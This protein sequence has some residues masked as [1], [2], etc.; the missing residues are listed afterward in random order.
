MAEGSKS[1]SRDSLDYHLKVQTL[2]D[3]LDKCRT[4]VNS[5]KGIDVT[6]EE[7][8]KRAEVLKMLMHQKRELLSNYK[9]RCPIE[10][11]P[12]TE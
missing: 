1:L 4:Q 12:R 6:K 8:I 5:V 11:V 10:G 9:N 2:K 7:Q 3:K